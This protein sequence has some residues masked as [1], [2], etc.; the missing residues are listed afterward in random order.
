MPQQPTK[1]PP[2]KQQTPFS[3][4]KWFFSTVD[5]RVFFPFDLPPLMKDARSMACGP[6][7]ST[8][9]SRSPLMSYRMPTLRRLAE[10]RSKSLNKIKD[11]QSKLYLKQSIII[12]RVNGYALLIRLTEVNDFSTI[13][14]SNC[15]V[16]RFSRWKSDR[17]YAI[18]S[19]AVSITGT[20]WQKKTL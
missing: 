4:Q 8:N 1:L 15:N 3:V 10:S 12:S 13:L 9:T 2:A 17:A 20:S 19:P 16:C 14:S 18:Q 11:Q 5:V 7:V 6:V